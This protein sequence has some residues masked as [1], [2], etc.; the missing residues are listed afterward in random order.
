MKTQH[1][2]HVFLLL[3]AIVAATCGCTASDTCPTGEY[4]KDGICCT[5]VCEK[6]CPAGYIEGTC[7][8]ECKNPEDNTPPDNT[9]PDPNIDDIF[10]DEQIDPP[11]I[12][13]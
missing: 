5:H 6:T 11:G 9:T 8:C 2:P 3:F 1:L 4:T 7:K 13:E 10:S 12:P